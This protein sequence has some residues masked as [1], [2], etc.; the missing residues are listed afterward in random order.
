MFVEALDELKSMNPDRA[1]RL[2]TI[3]QKH[4]QNFFNDRINELNALYHFTKSEEK[5][6]WGALLSVEQPSDT[7]SSTLSF[8]LLPSLADKEDKP[9]NP[10]E[11]FA[12]LGLLKLYWSSAWRE[13][14][15]EHKATLVARNVL[16]NQKTIAKDETAQIPIAEKEL[17]S[18]L[19]SIFPKANKLIGLPTTTELLSQK[20]DDG[21][22]MLD[23]NALN[24]FKQHNIGQSHKNTINIFKKI[25]EDKNYSIEQRRRTWSTP[26]YIEKMIA[27]CHW[28]DRTR[29]YVRYLQDKPAAL[30]SPIFQQLSRSMTR[31]VS[32]TDDGNELVDRNGKKVL[33]VKIDPTASL[34]I[35]TAQSMLRAGI[36]LLSSITAHQVL[37]WQLLEVHKQFA[38]NQKNPRHLVIEGGYQRLG[39]LCGAGT[40][41][42]VVDKIR[43]IIF[44]QASCLFRYKSQA[45]IWEG[46]LISFDHWQATGR[47]TSLLDIEMRAPACPGFVKQLPIGGIEL[48]EQRNLIPIVRLPSFVG[49]VN[50]HASQACF[51]MELFIEMRMR[52]REMYE[53]GGI[54]LSDDN[55]MEMAKRAQMPSILIKRVLDCWTSN[56]YLLER[57]SSVFDV[58]P[59]YPEAELMFKTAGKLELAGAISGKSEKKKRQSKFLKSAKAVAL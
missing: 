35:I 11:G 24:Y 44:A 10:D 45:G 57:E 36:P 59:R 27:T 37:R 49:R 13:F 7:Q 5:Q 21:I 2:Q 50:D 38:F 39:E 6:L 32:L 43:K 23:Q 29:K 41:K 20:N 53:R 4:R 54:F 26:L 47:K 15:E 12:L 52:A 48:Q 58:G 28:L 56:G 40:S 22:L 16:R 30:A 46:N 19:N 51:Q 18:D 17:I 55:L 25:I 3:Y 31:E 1:D 8:F 9:D 33:K 34:D 42:C 14:A